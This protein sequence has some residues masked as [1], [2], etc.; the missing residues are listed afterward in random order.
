MGGVIIPIALAIMSA[1]GQDRA[2]KRQQQFAA[3][4]SATSYQRAV[5]DMT[6][7][8][9]NPM[10]AYQQ[11]GAA[12]AS[13]NPQNTFGQTTNNIASAIAMRNET[14]LADE[15]AKNLK[16]TRA[17]TNTQA[18]VAEVTR[19]NTL[20]DY[21][22]KFATW[23]QFLAKL[24]EEVRAAKLGNDNTQAD[25]AYKQ[26]MS[27]IGRANATD[28]EFEAGK[29]KLLNDFGDSFPGGKVFKYIPG[30]IGGILGTGAKAY[31]HT[32]GAAMAP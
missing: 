6:K 5:T 9:L 8:G 2:N 15:Q 24:N 22:A 20:W 21:N 13:I 3:N 31:A 30:A 27:R 7:A 10:L 4:Q 29:T 17:L 18:D 11:G 12:N 19:K 16:A 32:F 28:A 1:I 23:D 26:A 25:T 14:K